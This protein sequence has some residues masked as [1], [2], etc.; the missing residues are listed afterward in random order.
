MII[1]TRR[2]NSFPGDKTIRIDAIVDGVVFPQFSVER[3]QD[4]LGTYYET[5]RRSNRFKTMRDV[6]EFA[7]EQATLEQKEILQIKTRRLDRFPTDQTIQVEAQQNGKTV[8]LFRIEQKKDKL[9]ATYFACD[10]FL[11][12]FKD[13]DQVKDFAMKMA[14]GRDR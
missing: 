3:K 2:L 6:K 10:C 5:D 11:G 1:K 12:T 9:G 13:M 8:T 14:K 7:M 4:R